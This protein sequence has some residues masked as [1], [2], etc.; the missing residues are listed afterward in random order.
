MLFL[1]RQF[2]QDWVSSTYVKYYMIPNIWQNPKKC[3]CSLVQTKTPK[4]NG[5]TSKK[6]IGVEQ[7]IRHGSVRMIPEKLLILEIFGTKWLRFLYKTGSYS[8]IATWENGWGWFSRPR[9]WHPTY[10]VSFQSRMCQSDFRFFS[11]FHFPVPTSFSFPIFPL[12]TV[13][14]HYPG[15]QEHMLC[16]VSMNMKKFR[17]VPTY[18]FVCWGLSVKEN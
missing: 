8:N 14:W 2:L 13:T 6:C 4:C 15:I 10:P 7:V 1:Q 11:Q 5:D 18:S 3:S 9:R 16:V 12:A 17:T